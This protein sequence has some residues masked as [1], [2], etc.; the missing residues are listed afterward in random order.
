MCIL[1]SK[2]LF[3]H[4][5]DE[6]TKSQNMHVIL[7]IFISVTVLKV[8]SFQI[9]LFMN[10]SKNLSLLCIQGMTLTTAPIEDYSHICP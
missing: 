8:N 1:G 10:A 5:A 6:Q 9:I 4:P 3:I 7:E 2:P